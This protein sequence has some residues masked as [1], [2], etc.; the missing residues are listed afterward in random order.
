MTPGGVCRRP[1]FVAEQAIL[2]RLEV[3][4]EV[5]CDPPADGTARSRSRSVSRNVSEA[6]AP[7]PLA[8]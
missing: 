6:K 4:E 8:T 5:G 1:G 2:H 3:L 7:S